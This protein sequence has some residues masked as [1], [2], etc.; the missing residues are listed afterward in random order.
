MMIP[1]PRA[2]WVQNASLLEPPKDA[3]EVMDDWFPTAA[4]A[5]MRR[6]RQLHATIG[7]AVTSLMVYRGSSEKMFAADANNVYE[8][9]APAD[10]EVAPTA[11]ISS[12]TGGDWSSINF[13]TSGGSFLWMCNGADSARHYN[14]TTWATPTITGVTSS[15]LSQV[16]AFGERIFAVEKDSLSA[17]YLPVDSVAGLMTEFALGGVFSRGGSLLF[18]GTWSLD[19][20][21]GVDD[22]CV[23]VTDQGEIAV[24]S[25]TDPSSDFSRKGVYH[26]APPLS[27]HAFFEAGGD[28]AI[29]TEDG[30]ISVAAAVQ[31]DRAAISRHAITYSIEDA[32]RDV[33]TLR[34]G[35]HS[36][37]CTI[38]HSQQM[39][40]VS[41]PADTQNISQAFIA[42]VRTGAWCRFTGWDVEA[43][44]V[45]DDG[46]Y[47]GTSSNTIY[48]AEVQGQDGDD[49]YTCA[50]L[51]KFR[52]MGLSVEL[53]TARVVYR[54]NVDMNPELT[55]AVDFEVEQPTAPAATSDEVDGVWGTANWGEFVWGAPSTKTVKSNWQTVKG[56]GH[57]ASVWVV[58]TSGRT[59]A[60]ETELISIQVVYGPG[61]QL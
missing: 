58:A 61:G 27:K 60:P 23:F 43:S 2:G 6:G 52:P 39:L 34:T 42:N 59:T 1:A 28:L 7:A 8:I 22:L 29:A 24:Y 20:G 9:T 49:A 37:N 44:A 41:V 30:I 33:V 16:W 47:F 55:G 5:R 13:G 15:N 53:L 26:I 57:E 31:Q 12:L 14:G 4:G 19:S 21:E 11:D 50:L 17:W 32:W 10:P 54:G 48:Q 18:G 40:V 51:P 56:V 46:L 25:G 36:F 45:F 35:A 3:A 38:W